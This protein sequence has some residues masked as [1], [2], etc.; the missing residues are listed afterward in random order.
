[1]VRLTICCVLLFLLFVI[2]FIADVRA[3][4]AVEHVSQRHRA[5]APLSLQISRGGT[6]EIVNDDGELTHHAYV[7]SP[8]FN[9]DSGEQ[10]PGDK[11]DIDFPIA[12]TFTV[13]CGIH[14][15][16]HLE[17]VVQ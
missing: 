12:G 8:Q 13:L 3:G 16:M 4:A 11:V 7:K 2:G 17:V 15:R 6:I 1:L 9:F 10:Q 5:F 14:P